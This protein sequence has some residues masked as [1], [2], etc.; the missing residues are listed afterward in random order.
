MERQDFA[1]IA[2]WIQPDT[3]VLDLGCGE[4]SL[5]GYLARE[6]QTRG[7]G[8]EIDDSHILA[9]V[10]N[11]V[12][13]IQ[14]DLE[15]GLAGFETG[16]FDYVI[17]SQTL[18]AMKNT[19]KIVAEMLRVGRQAIVS[20][21]NFGYW[22]NRWQLLCGNMPVSRHLPYQWYNTPN[23]HFCTLGDFEDFCTERHIRI[24]EKL[25]LQNG[26]PVSVLPNL[27]GNLAL[28][29]LQGRD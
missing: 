8:I 21:P 27:L 15:A 3:K 12:N 1:T 25:I 9:C 11:G 20:L 24:S 28:Y 7:Y 6:R 26:R 13:V 5:L 22:L 23:V 29:R 10:E 17:L 14:S 16:S 19:E 18:Q 2:S 4:G